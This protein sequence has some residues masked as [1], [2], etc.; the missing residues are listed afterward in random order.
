MV[1]RAAA[2]PNDVFV[3]MMTGMTSASLAADDSG[4]CYSSRF[5]DSQGGVFST[6]DAGH[7]R[8]V[9]E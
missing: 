8:S 2:E 6:P 7:R 4:S 9:E 3:N 1:V 5:A